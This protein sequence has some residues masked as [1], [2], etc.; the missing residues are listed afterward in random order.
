MFI[1]KFIFFCG[2]VCTLKPLQGFGAIQIERIPL[3]SKMLFSTKRKLSMKLPPA[4]REQGSH[5]EA[6]SSFYFYSLKVLYWSIYPFIPAR[7][8]S[9]SAVGLLFSNIFF[10]Y[11][12][13]KAPPFGPCLY[14]YLPL[15]FPQL[16]STATSDQQAALIYSQHSSVTPSY[17]VSKCCYQSWQ[18]LSYISLCQLLTLLIYI[19]LLCIQYKSWQTVKY[20]IITQVRETFSQNH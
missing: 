19:P 8:V 17:K 20:L 5:Q 9:S 12:F 1:F 16:F 3:S 11:R 10:N 13:P 14:V 2:L 15:C 6:L 7:R 4:V 18:R